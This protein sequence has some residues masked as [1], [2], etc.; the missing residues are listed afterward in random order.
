MAQSILNG[1]NLLIL[2]VFG[3]FCYGFWMPYIRGKKQEAVVEGYSHPFKGENR[4]TSFVCKFMYR[5]GNGK[6]SY[7][8]SK[9]VFDT[10]GEAISQ[11][12]KGS[13]VL[14]KVYK[15]NKD[16]PHDLA[17][18]ISDS[19]DRNHTLFLTLAAVLCCSAL[20]VGFHMYEAN[21]R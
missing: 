10:Q 4:D 6:S 20:A 9:R 16:D 2:I 13:K 12:P 18:I 1:T 19:K 5:E 15:E 3:F 14:L 11:Y 21:F 17:M 8:Y 7:C